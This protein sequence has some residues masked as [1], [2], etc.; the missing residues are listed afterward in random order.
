M[1]HIIDAYVPFLNF[2]ANVKK[3]KE[4]ETSYAQCFIMQKAPNKYQIMDVKNMLVD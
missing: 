3:P 2:A 4:N 1:P